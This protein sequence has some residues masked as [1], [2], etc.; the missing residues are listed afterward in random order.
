[1]IN[2]DSQ[3]V[4]M[5]SDYMGRLANL[6]GEFID[7]NKGNLS[8]EERNGLYDSEIE[9]A[10][11]AGEINIIGVN[12]LFEDIQGLL[13]D[14]DKI[15]EGVKNAVKKALAVQDAINIAAGLVTIGSAIVS[16]NPAAIAQSTIGVGKALQLKL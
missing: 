16:G 2:P 3:E 11:L 4:F 8:V 13:S 15:T 6:L 10:R 1:M 12:L 7:F 14:L 9:L 5:L